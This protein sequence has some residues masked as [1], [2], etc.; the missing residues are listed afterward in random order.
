MRVCNLCNTDL[1]LLG[2]SKWEAVRVPILQVLD[3]DLPSEGRKRQDWV[4]H[5]ALVRELDRA[6]MSKF[7]CYISKGIC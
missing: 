1:E 7:G 2:R 5:T 4:Q 3:L 6:A